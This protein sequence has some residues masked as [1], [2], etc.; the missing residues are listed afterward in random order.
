MPRKG[1]K[2]TVALN[3]TA[4]RAAARVL[5][6]LTSRRGQVSTR[7]SA[8]ASLTSRRPEVKALDVAANSTPVVT[9][10][11]FALLNDVFVGAN[12]YQRVGTKLA[13][14]NLHLKGYINAIATGAAAD[15]IQIIIVYDRQTNGALPT[16][17]DLISSVVSAGTTSST[18]LDYLNLNNRDRFQILRNKKYVLPTVTDTAG[19]LTNVGVIDGAYPTI[20]FDEFI[21]M[22]DM[23]TQFKGSGSGVVD[24]ASGSLL[25]FVQSQTTAAWQFT[26]SS[27]LRYD[28][29]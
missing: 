3:K 22:K 20:H 7:R 8:P 14:R 25:L 5:G 21:S 13:M 26:W 2:A 1:I 16:T 15:W 24:I 23:V 11:T 10:G 28:D 17:A 4:A 6:G 29:M 12:F 18:S 27:R 9:A 19:V